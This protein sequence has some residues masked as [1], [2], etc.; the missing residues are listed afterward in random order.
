MVLNDEIRN[1]MIDI[2]MTKSE[3]ALNSAIALSE[4]NDYDGAANRAYYSIFQSEYALLLSKGILRNSHKHTHNAIAEEFVKSGE[5]PIDTHMRIQIVQG[6]R[7][8]GDYS[9]TDIG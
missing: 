9:G 3:K 1:A 6:I 5:L 7:S 2:Y 4:L 8:T